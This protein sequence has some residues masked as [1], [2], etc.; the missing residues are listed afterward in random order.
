LALHFRRGASGQLMN[1]RNM[2]C[3]VFSFDVHVML[4]E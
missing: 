1:V 3:R 2:Q 4:F